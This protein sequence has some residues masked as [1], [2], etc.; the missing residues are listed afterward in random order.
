M[1]IY[2]GKLFIGP[3]M[4]ELY[5]CWLEPALKLIL[6]KLLTILCQSILN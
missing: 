2:N 1:Y 5:L 3:S 6:L 4:L